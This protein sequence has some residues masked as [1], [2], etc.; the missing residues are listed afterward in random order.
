M[1][2]TA[3]PLASCAFFLNY[4]IR[5]W[6]TPMFQINARIAL[7]VPLVVVSV[8]CGN[9]S[10]T[11]ASRSESD[12]AL[13][14]AA[15]LGTAQSFSVLAGSSVTN[16]GP[17]TLNGNLGVSP[18]TSIT[19]FPP[20]SVLVPATTHIADAV[21][22]QAES[23]VTT[24]YNALAGA[25]CTANKT[26]IDLGGQT[27]VT[28]VYCFSSSAQLTG[29][30]TLDAQGDPNAVFIFQVVSALTT[31]SGAS[32]RLINGADPC[33][34]F[35]QV[36]SSATVGSTTAFAGNILALTSI[37]LQTGAIVDGR[38]LARNGEVTLDS[39]TILSNSCAA[40]VV[41]GGAADA[42]AADAGAADAGGAVD[43]GVADAGPVCPGAPPSCA[44]TGVIAGPPK[45]LQIT[46]QDTDSGLQSIQ[47]TESN[48]ASTVVPSFTPGSK[49]ALVVVATKIDQASGA[50]VALRV[51]DVCGN[52]VDCDPLIGGEVPAAQANGG[53]CSQGG[54]ELF[55]LLG[56]AALWLRRRRMIG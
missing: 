43:G 3:T 52:V 6:R 54:S 19:G 39:N 44:L 51:T 33:N 17:T 41:D 42:G 1:R 36:G 10:S 21:A 30:L 49:A 34:V 15:S 53:G 28:G 20:G 48:N 22:G 35:W 16:I 47:V 14:S 38:A 13:T 24:A 40:V 46:V 8:A 50:Q 56:L 55:S 4:P 29:T 45:Q 18:G 5:F 12:Q 32:V 11:S 7:L 2:S 9:S 26:G 31:A 37:A 27:L 23:D 25:A